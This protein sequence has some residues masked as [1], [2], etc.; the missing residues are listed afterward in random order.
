[1]LIILWVFDKGNSSVA[2][3]SIPAGGHDIPIS[4]VGFDEEEPSRDEFSFGF[5]LG[6]NTHQVISYIHG[7]PKCVHQLFCGDV[8]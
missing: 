3:A 4:I 6:R 2:T 1:M 5:R 7:F 8:I